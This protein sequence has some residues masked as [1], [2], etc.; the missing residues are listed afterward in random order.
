MAIVTIGDSQSF[1]YTGNIQELVV[2]FSGVYKLEVWG[3]QGGT[4]GEGLN[5]GGKGGYSV[6]Y[7][8]LKQEDILYIC[9]G[10]AGAYNG[11]AS[12]N[13]G[14]AATSPSGDDYC[15][16]SGGGA[17]HIATVSGQLKDLSAYKDT[18]EILIVAGGGGGQ[19]NKW[20]D[21][22]GS[23]GKGGGLSGSST[24]GKNWAD[25][26]YTVAA[27]TQTSGYAFGQGGSYSGTTSTSGGGGGWY[28]GQAAIRG[29]GAGGSGYIGQNS[30]S[31]IVEFAGI[32]YTNTTSSGIR[33]GNGQAAITL[34]AVDPIIFNY[35]ESI[36]TYE[37][38]YDGIYKLEVWG[39]KGGSTNGGNGG[40]AVGYKG[41][42][43]GTKLYIVTGGA[44]ST[45][46]YGGSGGYNGGGA[47]RS[48][49]SEA[50]GYAWGG[51]GATHIAT[52]SGLLKN[53]STYQ[54]TGEILIVAG[55]GGGGVTGDNNT[56]GGAGGT[57]RTSHG[58]G[59]GFG[60]GGT[61]SYTV[62]GSGGG[63][64][65]WYGGQ[66]GSNQWTSSGGGSS[67]I[68]FTPKFT[69]DN[70]VYEPSEISGQNS[71]TGK[72]AITYIAP[73][74]LYTITYELNG[75][76]QGDNAMT[77]YNI[78]SETFDLPTPTRD[79]YIFK[80]W[81]ETADF[82]TAPVTQIIQGSVGDKTFYA[83][84]FGPLKYTFTAGAIHTF[85]V[86]FNGIW[87]LEC[88]GAKGGNSGGNGGYSIGYKELRAGDILYPCVGNVTYNGG[89]K[90]YKAGEDKV[91]V[92]DGGGCT[93]IA[94]VSGLLKDLSAYKDTGEILIVAGGGGGYSWKDGAAGYMRGGGVG[95]GPSGGGG[96][97]GGF[98]KGGS[99]G[100]AYANGC[101]GGGAGWKGGGWMGYGGTGWI[102]NVPTFTSGNV[103]YS[104][105]TVDGQHNSTSGKAVITW[106]ADNI[107]FNFIDENGD[108]VGITDLIFKGVSINGLRYANNNIYGLADINTTL[109]NTSI[110]NNDIF[111]EIGNSYEATLT[112][113]GNTTQTTVL[114][115]GLN[116]TANVYDESTGEIS[117]P[118]VTGDINIESKSYT[119]QVPLSLIP[120][121]LSGI[122]NGTG[123]QNNT[124]VSGANST[125]KTGYVSTG[126][127]TLPSDCE[128]FYVKGCTWDTTSSY[129]RYYAGNINSYLSYC[130]KADGTGDHGAEEFWTVETLDENYYKFTLNSGGKYYLRGR[131]FRM[132]LLGSGE[133]LS[134]TFDEPIPF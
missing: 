67:S 31:Y 36:Q 61:C 83:K 122:F 110:D 88:Y 91:H 130:V 4:D 17:T 129:C 11:G 77:T 95:G 49:E 34:V 85:T 1:S 14:G 90:G 100:S 86:P 30:D 101:P 125:S 134:I 39:S 132:S 27:G 33:S 58:A 104:P 38:P 2:P 15:T 68:K 20:N 41:L 72:A 84:W 128:A 131:Y 118:K 22:R 119:N 117:I 65:G 55:G 78:S 44:G 29:C 63:G 23:A 115:N 116:V 48:A 9:V 103:E 99:Y 3:A 26:T 50:E 124:Y 56:K 12:Y 54:G 6:R 8:Q 69:I 40:Y 66:Y 97:G 107:L 108:V 111:T 28:G 114:M 10:K 18:G 21:S 133:N 53:L 81:F 89:G 127:M 19:G 57:L 71:T 126:V 112:S 76:T 51:G 123:Y 96:T 52:V 35:K 73:A 102:G 106:V 62:N 93:H 25:S 79:N 47:G 37:V 75:G 98:G 43:A 45:G 94:T 7:V 5:A 16:Y 120:A 64:A 80:G 74:E 82:K 32:E 87:K 70:N 42:I 60:Y 59:A 46:T 13:G 24:T 105:S 113:Q 121:D 109:L 92:G